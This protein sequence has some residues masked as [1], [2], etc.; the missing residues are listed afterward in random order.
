MAEAVIADRGVIVAEFFV[1]GCSRRVSW[2]RRTEAA[3]LLEQ[4]RSADRR[5]DAVVMGEFER[6]FTDRQ[7]EH[8]ARVLR[9]PGVQVWLAGGGRS[10]PHVRWM[11]AE[12]LAGRSV[13][14]ILTNPRY[15]GRQ[16]WSR[17]RSQP[18]IGGRSTVPGEWVVSTTLA[19]PAL[20][21]EAGFV[22]VQQVRASRECKD[23][24]TRNYVLAGLGQ[25]WLCGRR[26]DS[27][28]VNRRAG[29]RCRHGHNSAWTRQRTRRATSTCAR[30]F[31]W[32]GSLGSWSP[33]GTD[34]AATSS[35]APQQRSSPGYGPMALR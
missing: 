32:T 10:G 35:R 31:S 21:N 16:V 13:A 15:T 23:G 6:A 2:E 22:A 29:Y 24:A 3:A 34:P 4:A 30:T 14:V 27:H 5:F 8:V 33:T 12:R 19:H 1:I 11:F 25:C 7:F 18:C 20:V 9:Q 17:Q 28:W 26:M